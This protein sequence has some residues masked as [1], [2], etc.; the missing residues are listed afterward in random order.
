MKAKE[1]KKLALLGM[2]GGLMT[3]GPAAA[4]AVTD[5]NSVDIS[6]LMAKSKCEAHGCGAVAERDVHTTNVEAD[7]ADDE[8]ESDAEDQDEG[9]EDQVAPAKKAEPV[10]K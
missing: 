4:E 9:D 8:D 10:K 7:E 5:L 3:F 2:A 6:H 1:L